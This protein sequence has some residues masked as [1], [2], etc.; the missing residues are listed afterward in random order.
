M[1]SIKSADYHEQSASLFDSAHPKSPPVTVGVTPAASPDWDEWEGSEGFDFDDP[2]NRS[3][4]FQPAQHVIK[5]ARLTNDAIRTLMR[6]QPASANLFEVE[7]V[8]RSDLNAYLQCSAVSFPGAGITFNRHKAM[9]TF[10]IE[11]YD[12]A[13]EVTF[14][15]RE[16][17]DF[18]VRRFHENW[19]ALFYNRDD[20]T[21]QSGGQRTLTA[22]ISLQSYAQGGY[23]ITGRKL[24]LRGM[25]PT[26]LP[27]LSLDWSNSNAMEYT[28]SYKVKEWGWI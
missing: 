5:S 17:S 19:F 11:S 9:K 10:T 28:L 27:D 16:S 2:A 1:E 18:N 12:Y 24:Q 22:N 8:G 15:W 20:D 25:L 26:K 6:W 3:D 4:I 23:L 7:F 13:D 14:T 21:Y